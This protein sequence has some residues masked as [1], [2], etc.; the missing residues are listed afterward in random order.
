MQT[1]EERLQKE[2]SYVAAEH[3]EHAPHRHVH[4]LALVK[5]RLN[6]KD[7]QALRQTATDAALFQR[8]ERD[9]QRSQQVQQQKGAQWG[10]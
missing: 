7:F 9:Q 8:Q 4:V 2:V 1:L 6:T 3:D 5:G 10:K